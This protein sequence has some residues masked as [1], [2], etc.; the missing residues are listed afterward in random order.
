[1]DPALIHGTHGNS[2]HPWTRKGTGRSASQ[3]HGKQGARVAAHLLYIS[4]I[5]SYPSVVH[6][7][8]YRNK[9]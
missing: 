1:M 9:S 3:I 2:E 4:G 8:I 6:S 5:I 7:F